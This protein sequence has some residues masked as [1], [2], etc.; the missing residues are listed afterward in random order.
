[1]DYH[2]PAGQQSSGDTKAAKGS[3]NT[4]LC[5]RDLLISSLDFQSGGTVP[6]AAREFTP[7]ELR[8]RI[9]LDTLISYGRFRMADDGD[10]IRTASVV[11]AAKRSRMGARDNSFLVLVADDHASD[12]LGD[13]VPIEVVY[14]GRLINIYY[15]EFIEDIEND[16]R[17]PFILARVELCKDTNG[18]DA[19]DPET[20]SVT[21]R[22][23][24]SDDLFHIATIEAVIGRINM[25]NNEWGIIDCSRDGARTDFRDEEGEDPDNN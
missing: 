10:R 14:Y 13:D 22:K 17:K 19:T 21:Y 23:L 11:D 15:I 9:D 6:Y 2:D 25:G 18:V 4:S 16:I 3:L 5:T 1:M 24:D 20:P 7:E 12:I 8:A